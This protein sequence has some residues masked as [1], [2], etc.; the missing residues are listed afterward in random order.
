M[1]FVK[2]SGATKTIYLPVTTG[3]AFT[4]GTIVSFSAGYLIPATSITTALSHIGVIKKDIALTDSDIDTARSVPVEVPVERNV[5]WEAPVTATLVVADVG[6]LVNL[7]DAGTVDR[8][9]S[10]TV[11]IGR[12]MKYI[13]TTKGWFKLNLGGKTGMCV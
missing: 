6:E 3:T 1:A 9:S 11:A 10:G 4:K 8:A 5:I 2:K 7:T 13:S 12:C